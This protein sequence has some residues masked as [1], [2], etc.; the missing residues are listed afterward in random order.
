M[1]DFISFLKERL[2]IIMLHVHVMCRGTHT[3]WMLFLKFVTLYI[4]FH[5]VEFGKLAVENEALNLGQ[6]G[7]FSTEDDVTSVEII[8]YW[9]YISMII[10]WMW[11][12]TYV[13]LFCRDSPT[14]SRHNTWL[15]KW[16]QR[17]PVTTT[18]CTSTHGAL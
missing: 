5:R 11:T 10:S 6:V 17:L 3:R 9:H 2:S 16:W 12:L 18:W 13:H 4:F 15:T 7:V 8:K 1:D 14:L